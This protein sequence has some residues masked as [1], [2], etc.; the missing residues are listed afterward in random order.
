VDGAAH[1]YTVIGRIGEGG[2]GQVYEVRDADGTR[3]AAKLLS[4]ERFEITS[5][6]R[7]RFR[8]EAAIAARF[9][10]SNVVRTVELIQRGPDLVIVMEHVAG[11]R[12]LDE[13]RRDRSR[14][15]VAIAWMRQLAAGLAYLHEQEIIHRDLAP[16]NVLFREYPQMVAL[17][18][19][20]VARHVADPTLTTTTEHFGSLLYI[21]PQQKTDPHTV[22]EA[23]DVYSLG[24]IYAYIVSGEEPH[25]V[26]GTLPDEALDWGYPA[27]LLRLIDRMRA[28]RRHDRPR[29]G[30][31]VAA[32]LE[33][34]VS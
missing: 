7:A 17:C 15:P 11:P 26:G 24:Q 5:T 4:T 8:R 2:M 25:A 1:R 9:S 13:L 32:V 28:P 3:F 10:H 12:L 19:F 23:D 21:S 27:P 16:K 14:A 30:G 22:T 29:D 34:A 33:A 20:G 6:V 18:D 31:E